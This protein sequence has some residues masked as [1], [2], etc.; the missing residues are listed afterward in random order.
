M[1][2]RALSTAPSTTLPAGETRLSHL[3]RPHRRGQPRGDLP[4]VDA[5]DV[6]LRGIRNEAFT[7]GVMAPPTGVK[8]V[9]E[10]F[11]DVIRHAH[12]LVIRGKRVHASCYEAVDGP[13]SIV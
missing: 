11:H 8:E 13:R 5:F 6:S 7:R 9:V 12:E 3:P 1:L 2:P 10:R 4:L